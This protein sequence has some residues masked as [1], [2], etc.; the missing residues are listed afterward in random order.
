MLKSWGAWVAQ[1]AERLPLAQVMIPGSWD[2]ALCQAPC[3]V[4][5][6]LLLLPLFFPP[7]CAQT[8]Y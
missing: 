2:R 3:S 8:L 6:L 5:S 7:T 1:S 4:G